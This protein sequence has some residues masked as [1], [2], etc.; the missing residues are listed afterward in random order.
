M[1]FY[2]NLVYFVR[3][4]FLFVIIKKC[5]KVTKGEN[6][7]QQSIFI[8]TNHQSN[9]LKFSILDILYQF[10]MDNYKYSKIDMERKERFNLIKQ[11]FEQS[12]TEKQLQEFKTIF[13]M[14]IDFNDAE[15]YDMLKFAFFRGRE[16]CYKQKID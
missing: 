10:F 1:L 4:R 11:E 6:M 15:L 3:C 2:T 7:K 14:Q 8:Q 12:L 13:V 9:Y 16:L 5:T